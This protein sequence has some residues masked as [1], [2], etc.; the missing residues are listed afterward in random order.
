MSGRIHNFEEVPVGTS[1]STD[2]VI[3]G[4]GC[5]GAV[6]AASL[7]EKGFNVVVVEEGRHWKIEEF[8][9]D[10][11][12]AMEKLYREKGMRSAVGNTVITLPVAR[13]LGGT[14]V[15]NSSICFRIPD[16]VLD[17]WEKETG[18]EIDREELSAHYRAAEEFLR[19]GKP[20][21]EIVTNND[22]LHKEAADMLGWNNDYFDLNAPDCEGCNRCNIGCPVGGKT[23]MDMSYIP[24]AVAAG[25]RIY[26]CTRADEIIVRKGISRGIK[27][28]VQDPDSGQIRGVL[29]ILARAVV[30]AAGAIETPV[31]LMKNK[32]CS[33]SGWLGHNLHIHPATGVFGFFP[34]REIK[35]W[36]GVFQ[37]HYIDE[38]IEDGFVIE[39]ASVPPEAI[40]SAM[41]FIG[42]KA[43]EILKNMAHFTSSGAMIRDSSKGR[44]KPGDED[45]VNITY[46]VNEDD[47]RK[48]IEGMS[49]IA[50]LL[51]KAGA[52]W[53]R[54]AIYTEE[55]IYSESDILHVLSHKHLKPEHIFLYASHPQGTARMGTMKDRT[56][57]DM[58][59]ET[60]EVKGLFIV[61]ASVFPL[62]AGVNPQLTIMA[63]ASY[64]AERIAS[65]I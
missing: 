27:C 26:T 29:E 55:F 13:M 65:K 37:G 47:R 12:T 5:G 15:V 1:I 51:L 39:T 49:K 24:R 59:G 40:F 34:D 36:R 30:L 58:N 61:D 31:L 45:H 60:H 8:P 7:A 35:L 33:T 52:K 62:A 2:V 38:F 23:S 10:F 11:V 48:Y 53:V 50:L 20:G 41:P 18:F 57:T 32:L 17:E 54:P 42:K 43:V 16:F 3:I 22:R 44:V 56:V 46:F 25:A 19:V 64:L 6:A 63:L 28:T 14:S 9:D 4:S 21:P